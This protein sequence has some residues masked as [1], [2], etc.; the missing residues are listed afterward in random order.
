MSK[1]P[2]DVM[3]AAQSASLACING[4]CGTYRHD[5][6]LMPENERKA[7]YVTMSQLAYHDVA[8]AI[9]Q[10]I[11]AERERCAE[12]TKIAVGKALLAGFQL[13]F[14]HDHGNG[15]YE[16]NRILSEATDTLND[17]RS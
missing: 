16:V 17:Q 10:A 14:T 15:S 7:L 9:A 5:Y 12:A 3:K 11:M 8:P 1:I 6:G 4:M 2:E 13:G